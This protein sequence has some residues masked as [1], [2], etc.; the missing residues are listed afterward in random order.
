[1]PSGADKTPRPRG[2]EKAQ[3][4]LSNPA[5]T[6]SPAEVFDDPGFSPKEGDGATSADVGAADEMLDA[7]LS[8]GEELSPPMK[9]SP[10][11]PLGLPRAPSPAVDSARRHLT[12]YGEWE[13]DERDP[14]VLDDKQRRSAMFRGGAVPVV[15]LTQALAQQHSLSDKRGAKRGPKRGGKA[16]ARSKMPMLD[17]SQLTALYRTGDQH[18]PGAAMRNLDAA[19][20]SARLPQIMRPLSRGV[21]ER[22]VP[23][24]ERP[25]PPAEMA[26][27]FGSEASGG[28]GK[29]VLTD[30]TLPKAALAVAA[31]AAKL[32]EGWAALCLAPEDAVE[33][34]L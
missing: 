16:N 20:L 18:V 29:L 22:R 14:I 9:A 10:P 3:R 4:K 19:A 30:A 17:F 15:G 28:G 12:L 25:R 33:Y 21:P 24:T 11:S 27:G 34:Q 7:V 13:R 31:A 5:R 2:S 32:P 1:M 8:P 6:E 26:R 23:Q